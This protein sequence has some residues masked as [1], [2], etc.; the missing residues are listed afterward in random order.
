MKPIH[1]G[2]HC[3]S[4][5]W[6]D[7]FVFRSRSI[8]DIFFNLALIESC[9]LHA[10]HKS[11]LQTGQLSVIFQRE[12]PHRCQLRIERQRAAT[13]Q[14]LLNHSI[15]ITSSVTVRAALLQSTTPFE[16][17]TQFE[18][19]KNLADG[20]CDDF[21]HDCKPQNPTNS[22]GGRCAVGQRAGR[23]LATRSSLMRMQVQADTE[24]KCLPC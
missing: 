8:C 13:R 14:V 23:R 10:R 1:F 4:T 11:P 6:T 7:T 12:P 17:K 16:S 18:G 15:S 22:G 21:G 2:P 19:E 24:R 9:S 5:A 3:W 20:R